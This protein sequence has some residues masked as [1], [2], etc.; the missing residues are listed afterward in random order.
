MATEFTLPDLGENIT[1]GDVVSVLVSAGDTVTAGQAVL[2]VE[3]DKAVIEVPCPT[4]GVVG[5]VLVKKGE[6]VNVGQPLL[7]FGAA[8]AAPA[9]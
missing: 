4:A 3:T 1:S 7:T 2:E 6:T 8:A 9:A 5:E